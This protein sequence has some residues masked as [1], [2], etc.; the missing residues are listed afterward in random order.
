[1]LYASAH[2]LAYR[3]NIVYGRRGYGKIVMTV[4]EESMQVAVKEVKT[5]PNSESCGTVIH[6]TCFAIHT[7]T[8]THT[9]TNT[10]LSFSSG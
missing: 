7:H 9:N 1:M 3:Y 4:A 6:N 2:S 5:Q 8:Y 10:P